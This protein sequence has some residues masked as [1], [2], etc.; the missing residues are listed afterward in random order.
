MLDEA[1]R[2]QAADRKLNNRHAQCSLGSI[3][4]PFG[5]SEACQYPFSAWIA[6]EKRGYNAV[7]GDSTFARRA[8][9]VV[10]SSQV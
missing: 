4:L 5:T 9:I 3:R 8:F 10:F 2:W 1:G 6:S 7:K